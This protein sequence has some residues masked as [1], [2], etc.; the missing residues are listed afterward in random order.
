MEPIN[1]IERGHHRHGGPHPDDVPAE[2]RPYWQRAHRDWRVL[3]GLFFCLAAIII[4]VMSQDLAW[5]PGG[6]RQPPS[7]VAR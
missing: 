2:R 6:R 3:V 7:S 5:L 4:Y 1:E